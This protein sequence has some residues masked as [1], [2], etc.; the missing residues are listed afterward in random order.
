[1]FPKGGQTEAS[2]PNNNCIY[3][4]VHI[5]ELHIHFGQFRLLAPFSA[6]FPETAPEKICDLSA[7]INIIGNSR[8]WNL[9]P[10]QTRTMLWENTALNFGYLKKEK[11]TEI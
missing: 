11:E 2:S 4:K 6:L 7:F 3:N 9:A 1:M 8:A 10:F 5:R